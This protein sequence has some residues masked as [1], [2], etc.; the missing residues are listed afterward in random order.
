[1]LELLWSKTLSAPSFGHYWK[2]LIRSPYYIS[3]KWNITL[4]N[5]NML[6]KVARTKC[7]LELRQYKNNSDQFDRIPHLK[8]ARFFITPIRQ[9]E[10]GG[11][12]K[13]GILKN[14]S[15]L[16]LYCLSSRH[17]GINYHVNFSWLSIF[18]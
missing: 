12:F 7:T 9:E 6:F 10:K 1:M 16:F 13:R 17:S 2:Q 3:N 15:E 8:L 4:C 5:S 14:W 18:N 11:N